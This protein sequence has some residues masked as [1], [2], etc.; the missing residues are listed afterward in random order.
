VYRRV[1]VEYGLLTGALICGEQN[2]CDWIKDQIV[3]E[4]QG[5]RRYW[6]LSPFGMPQVLHAANRVR[7]MNVSRAKSQ[8]VN[9]GQT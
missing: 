9:R 4:Q 1:L 3:Q 7:C 2:C 6:L 8:Q 5:Q